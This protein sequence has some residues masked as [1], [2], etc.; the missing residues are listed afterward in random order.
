MNILNNAVRETL[1]II[2]ELEYTHIFK[3]LNKEGI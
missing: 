2:E 1:V 3:V